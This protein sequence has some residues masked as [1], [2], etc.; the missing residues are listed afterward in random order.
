MWCL[1]LLCMMAADPDNWWVHYGDPTL[2]MLVNKALSSN[3]DI[4]VA[5]QRVAQARALTGEAKS[6]LQP[7]INLNA[8]AQKLRGGY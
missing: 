1:L 6:A 2:D 3:L 4:K 8:G 5:A 7:S